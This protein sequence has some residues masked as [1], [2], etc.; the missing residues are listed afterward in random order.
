TYAEL[1]ERTTRLANA[2]LESG[3]R[4]GDRIATWMEDGIAYVEVYLAAAKA[5]LVVAPINARFVASEAD[6]QLEDAEAAALVWTPGLAE[7]VA[8][9]AAHPALR[10]TIVAGPHSGPEPTLEDLVARGSG[11]ALSPPGPE[12][13]FIL[14]YT[15]G[16]TG[17]PK[18]AMLTHRSVLSIGRQNALSF[19]LSGHTVF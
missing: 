14:G 18:G 17:S 11:D 5:G 9:L 12:D 16:T 4:R 15:S 3:L 6:Y 2:L 8:E 19:R 1:D 7:R 10:M 13:L